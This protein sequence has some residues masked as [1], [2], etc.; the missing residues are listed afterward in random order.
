MISLRMDMKRALQAITLITAIFVGFMFFMPVSSVSAQTEAEKVRIGVNLIGGK[1]E[2]R[3][4]VDTVQTIV[5]VFLFLIGTVAVIMLIYGGFRYVTSAGDASAVTSAKNT[6]IY[7]VVGIVVA[8][9][10]YAITSFVTGVF[11]DNVDNQPQCNSST[12]PGCDPN[13]GT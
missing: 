10:A 9:S 2:N 5:G 13:Q 1:E 3:S 8:I 12:D 11:D 6:I 7:A 4:F